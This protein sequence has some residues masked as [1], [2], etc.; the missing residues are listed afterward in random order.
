MAAGSQ[1]VLQDVL[2]LIDTYDLYGRPSNSRTSAA[3]RCFLTP[4]YPRKD[5]M[6]DCIMSVLDAAPGGVSFSELPATV[7]PSHDW[8]GK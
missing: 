1:K 5:A 3:P 4:E 7:R 2:K 6:W 8:L